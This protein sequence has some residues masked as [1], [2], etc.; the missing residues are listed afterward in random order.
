M[1]LNF[2]PALHMEQFN[3]R[4][5]CKCNLRVVFFFLFWQVF[6]CAMSRSLIINR[7]NHA[8]QKQCKLTHAHSRKQF[9]KQGQNHVSMTRLWCTPTS[10]T[11]ACQRVQVIDQVWVATNMT[12]VAADN[13]GRGQQ[14]FIVCLKLD[15]TRVCPDAVLLDIPSALGHGTPNVDVIDRWLRQQ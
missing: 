2:C 1:S 9:A 11:F 7:N 12:L 14:L 5:E 10:Q 15:A 4:R 13:L 8:P 6:F 3:S